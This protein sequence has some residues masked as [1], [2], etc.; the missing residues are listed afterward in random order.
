LSYA[1][2]VA[3]LLANPRQRQ[4]SLFMVEL[5]HIAMRP[6]EAQAS[7]RE[8]VVCIEDLLHVHRYEQAHFVGHSFGTLVLTWVA[9]HKLSMVSRF[10]FLDPV[11]F[12]LCK[13]DVAYNL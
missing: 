11:C 9:K 5:P 6:V 12:L 1:T 3:E 10:T 4:V 2:V 8:L 13:H 7:P